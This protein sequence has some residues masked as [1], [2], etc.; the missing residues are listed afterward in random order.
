[1]Q[2]AQAKLLKEGM[3]VHYGPVPSSTPARSQPCLELVVTRVHL[4]WRSC[5]AGMRSWAGYEV[6][7]YVEA[8]ELGSFKAAHYFHPGSTLKHLHSA[9]ACSRATTISDHAEAFAIKYP[10]AS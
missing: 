6:L 9:Q 8:S 5:G 2:I 4:K 10:N 3:L 1:M 7:Q